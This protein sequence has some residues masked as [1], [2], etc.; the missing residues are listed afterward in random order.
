MKRKQVDSI[1]FDQARR[2]KNIFNYSSLIIIL[3]FVAF[4]SFY[5]FIYFNKPEY[6][7]YNE[8]SDLDYKVYLKDNPFIKEEYSKSNNQYIAS[9]I[10]F[11]RAD[12]S[13]DLRA[14]R[15]VDFQYSYKIVANVN[16]S[17]KSTHKSLYKYSEDL[18]NVDYVS[19]NG[20]KITLSKSVDIDYNRYN[21][22]IKRFVGVYDIDSADSSLDVSMYVNVKG[23][24]D[25]DNS[26][27][28]QSVTT[29]SIPL[30]VKTFDIDMAYNV[31]DN[32][33]EKIMLCDNDVTKY[34]FLVV[35]GLILVA[36]AIKVIL[37][38]IRYIL[39]TRTAENIYDRE[40]KKILNNY[41]S[42]IQKVETGLEFTGYK[43]I[44]V[45]AFT[46]MLEI[47]DTI[48]EPILMVENKN[49]NG[50]N[51]Y[52]PG[53]TKM[54]YCYSLKVSDIKFKMSEKSEK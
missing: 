38:L 2:K 49:G 9:M 31:V 47:R 7:S 15:D 40:L 46:D 52:I 48:Q 18:V 11:V 10:D 43:I 6:V 41:K 1:L 22:L 3:L 4:I 17:D 19:T 14:S 21:D 25:P 53:K 5:L 28:N 36:I 51:F 20:S 34:K 8:K 13:Y 35:I 29:L 27:S 39:I 23:N 44:K 30:T 12:F 32:A 24:C 45:E 37:T 16:V 33:N 42:Y 26:T 50:V 54:V